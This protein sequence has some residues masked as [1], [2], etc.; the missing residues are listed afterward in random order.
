MD[1]WNETVDKAAELYGGNYNCCEAIMLAVGEYLGYDDDLLLKISTPFGS[2]LINNGGTCGS[3][4]AAYLCM[5]IFKGRTSQYESRDNACRPANRI[6]EK[7]CKMYGSPNCNDIVGYNKKDTKAVELYGK[8]IK[9]EVCIPLT[10]K[11]TQWI[12]EELD[13]ESV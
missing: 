12:L 1:K 10:Q 5:G 6:F 3:L 13:N 11:V 2:G 9:C 8:K 7:F 4:L